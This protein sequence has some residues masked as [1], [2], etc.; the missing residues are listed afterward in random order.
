MS[1]TIYDEALEIIDKNTFELG[2]GLDVLRPI[3]REVVVKALVQAQKQEQ[4]RVEYSKKV[5]EQFSNDTKRIGELESKLISQERLLGFYKSLI[6]IK[7]DML[8]CCEIVDDD[9]Y[10]IEKIETL[11]ESQIKVL[12]VLLK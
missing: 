3:Y 8:S 11:F 6:T 4:E 9:Y 2:K 7:D 5:Q 1:K 12:E 10:D